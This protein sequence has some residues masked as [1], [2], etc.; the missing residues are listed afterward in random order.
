M[1]DFTD[2]REAMINGQL[3]PNKIVD[4][5]VL[6]AIRA[7]PRELFVP[8]AKRA[9]A[10]VDEDIEV[11]PGRWLMEPVVFGRLIEAAD[12]SASD[13]VLDIGCLHGYSAAVFAQLANVVVGVEDDAGVVER[14]NEM[15]TE[16]GLGTAAVVEN[17]LVDGYDKE[18]P[19]DVVFIGG[20]VER[21]PRAIV[22]QLAEGGRLITVQVKN[23]VGRCVLGKK[24]AGV[25]GLSA[26]M[27]AQVPL[28]DAFS[29]PDTF[30]F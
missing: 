24:V 14:A 28:L 20:A 16:L 8:K 23:G 10:Y 21:I 7:V 29:L 5:A 22:D 27:D 6:S 11:L 15:L 3:R 13:A 1:S 17:T 19:F 4:A 9:M 30:S 25:F 12:I 18:A 26:F 2:A